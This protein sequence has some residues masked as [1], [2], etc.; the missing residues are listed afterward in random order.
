MYFARLVHLSLAPN[1]DGRLAAYLTAAG[2]VGAAMA[3]E[4]K[5]I[6]V[7]NNTVQPFGI[8]GVVAH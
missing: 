5:A 3:S 7:G 6:V 2:A 8:N 4:A 1:L